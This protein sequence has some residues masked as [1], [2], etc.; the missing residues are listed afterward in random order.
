M[1]PPIEEHQPDSRYEPQDLL[2]LAAP[3]DADAVRDHIC[4]A[5]FD[6]GAFVHRQTSRSEYGGGLDYEL[7]HAW[8]ARAVMAA[9]KLD[10]REEE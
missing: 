7:L 5:C 1:T 9:L 2:P 3:F 4:R 6:P 10:Q 8:Q